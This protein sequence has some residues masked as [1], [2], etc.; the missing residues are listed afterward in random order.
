MAH[1]SRRRSA[2]V[3]P[4]LVMRIKANFWFFMVYEGENHRK[5]LIRRDILSNERKL[6]RSSAPF[7]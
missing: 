7:P 1:Y 3:M 2:N 6:V 5:R 4:I